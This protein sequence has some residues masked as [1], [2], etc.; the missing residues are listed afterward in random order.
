MTETEFSMLDF[1]MQLHY[2][3]VIV[4]SDVR[5]MSSIVA[6]IRCCKLTTRLLHE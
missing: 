5:V 1:R 4:V 3:H 2:L 6:V